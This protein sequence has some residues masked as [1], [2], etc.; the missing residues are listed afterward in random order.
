MKEGETPPGSKKVYSP[1]GGTGSVNT[2]IPLH[3]LQWPLRGKAS[4][5]HLF[6]HARAAQQSA[7]LVLCFHPSGPSVLTSY[8]EPSALAKFLLPS[9]DISSISF[10][11]HKMCYWSDCSRIIRVTHTRWR[12]VYQERSEP[13]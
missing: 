6:S 4:A 9:N 5:C 2:C 13:F 8:L 11:E 12:V 1:L 7:I 3:H 10:W